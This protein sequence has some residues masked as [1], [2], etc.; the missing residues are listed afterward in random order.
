MRIGK[1]V[2]AV[3]WQAYPAL[4]NRL[5]WRLSLQRTKAK[6]E[7]AL[8]PSE[9]EA[10]QPET[11]VAYLFVTGSHRSPEL[12]RSRC[13]TFFTSLTVQDSILMMWETTYRILSAQNALL[14]SLPMNSKRAARFRSR[15]W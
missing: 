7:K 8:L 13:D 15:V 10:F 12:M 2:Q 4:D 1:K 11:D 14:T 5:P 9:M 6:Q 3:L